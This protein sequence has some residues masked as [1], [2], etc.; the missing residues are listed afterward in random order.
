MKY[1]TT[2]VIACALIFG[3]AMKLQAQEKAAQPAASQE[4][5]AA[6]KKTGS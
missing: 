6:K 5:I 4:E 1:I 3:Y 2:V